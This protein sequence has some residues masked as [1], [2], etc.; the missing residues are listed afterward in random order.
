[1]HVYPILSSK[2]REVNRKAMPSYL[3]TSYTI[4]HPTDPILTQIKEQIQARIA[5]VAYT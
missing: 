2:V 1:M 3:M 4:P 5:R